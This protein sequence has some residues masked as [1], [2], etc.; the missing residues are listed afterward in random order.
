MA[1]YHYTIEY[2]DKMTIMDFLKYANILKEDEWQKEISLAQ[3]IQIGN[4]GQEEQWEEFLMARGVVPPKYQDLMIERTPEE[5]LSAI[6]RLK[7]K[8]SKK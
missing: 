1:R 3:I 5:R 7:E 6:D 4:H 8:M 2:I